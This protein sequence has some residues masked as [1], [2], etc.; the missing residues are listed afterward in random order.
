M[1]NVSDPVAANITCRWMATGRGFKLTR[2]NR[3][4]CYLPFPVYAVYQ[5]PTVDECQAWC[6]FR[7]N[8]FTGR[9]V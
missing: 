5:L 3:L 7:A 8:A 9:L 4:S 2:Y 6:A 1:L